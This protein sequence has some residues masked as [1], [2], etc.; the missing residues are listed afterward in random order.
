[1]KQRYLLGLYIVGRRWLEGKAGCGDFGFSGET[2]AVITS[3][4]ER[5]V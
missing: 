3:I 2:R 1:M 4:G 5:A